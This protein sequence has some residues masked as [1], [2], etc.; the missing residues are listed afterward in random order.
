MSN[1]T[2]RT[3]LIV[4]AITVL[5][6]FCAVVLLCSGC[7]GKIIEND[8]GIH[9]SGIQN[10]DDTKEKRIENQLGY[11]GNGIC[12]T[13]ESK[14][15]CWSDCRPKRYNDYTREI[16]QVPYIPPFKGPS[17]PPPR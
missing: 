2:N 10:V 15:S 5:V 3:F 4:M 16:F 17:Q 8:T 11:C 9:D 13:G 6:Y 12:E 1:R 7:G 14:E